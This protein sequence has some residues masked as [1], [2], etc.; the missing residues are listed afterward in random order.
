MLLHNLFS[1]PQEFETSK[2]IQEI[3][4]SHFPFRHFL[5]W[6]S[7]HMKIDYPDYVLKSDS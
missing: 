3:L 1:F 5:I 2:T 4:Y 6:E 7:F